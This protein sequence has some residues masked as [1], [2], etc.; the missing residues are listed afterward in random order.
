MTQGEHECLQPRMHF[1]LLKDIHKVVTDRTDA[2]IEAFGNLFVAQGIGE[3][4]KHI[5]LSGCKPL[6]GLLRC[7]VSLSRTAG[8]PEQ[9]EDLAC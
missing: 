2:D 5:P 3:R 9:L 8:D 7:V 4:L 6:D 1:E